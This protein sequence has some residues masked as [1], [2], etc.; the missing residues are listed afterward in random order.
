MS[1]PSKRI[2]SN[3]KARSERK[4]AS[5]AESV[6]TSPQLQFATAGSAPANTFTPPAAALNDELCWE[7]LLRRDAAFDGRFYFGVLTTGVFCRPSC[8]ARRP[9]R[10]N[11]RFF[12]TPAQAAESGLRPCLRCHPLKVSSG[13]TAAPW[14]E[15]ACRWIEQHLDD[16]LPLQRIASEFSLSP[17]HFQRSFKAALGVSPREFIEALRLQRLKLRL[18]EGASVVDAMVDAGYGSSSRLYEKTNPQLGMTPTRYR[19]GAQGVEIR[20]TSVPTPLGLM[21][22]AATDKGICFLQFGDDETSLKADLQLEYPGAHAIADPTSLAP[23]V[24]ALSGYFSGAETALTLPVDVAATAFQRKVW[25]YL[26]T[27]PAGETRS[28]GQVA[29]ALGHEK[30]YRAVANACANNRVALAVPCHRVVRGT[31]D[32]GGY[33]WGVDRKKQLLER[34]KAALESHKRG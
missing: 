21:L 30:A 13:N 22:L 27:I 16:Q 15:K 19:A 23:F 34:E 1:G 4:V 26:Q 10:Q 33:R 31:G 32:L 11:V 6:M 7:A 28:Y 14:V 25:T 12:E 24:Q 18:R 20:F 5:G 8:P 2:N 29:T 17:F 3:R 9:L